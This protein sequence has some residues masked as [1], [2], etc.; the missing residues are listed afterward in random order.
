MPEPTSS[1]SNFVPPKAI[2]LANNEVEKVKNKGPQ[3]T[4]SAPY[5]ILTPTQ[6]FEVGKRAAEHGVTVFQC[7]FAKKYPEL[8]L[9]ETSIRR[10]KNLY[11]CECKQHGVSSAVALI[12]E[13]QELPQKKEGRPLLLPDELDQQVQ[14]YLK[15]LV[16]MAWPSIQQ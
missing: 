8:P 10:L 3:G 2:K 5:L 14:E 11:H 12:E 7:Y 9:E 6:R 4:R 15:E 16:N 1:L 13:V